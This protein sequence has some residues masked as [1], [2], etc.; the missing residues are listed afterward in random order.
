VRTLGDPAV[1]RCNVVV[2]VARCRGRS[3]VIVHTLNGRGKAICVQ[4]G[5]SLNDNAPRPALDESIC[6]K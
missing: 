2:W 4:G 1:N 5:L 6:V 3:S